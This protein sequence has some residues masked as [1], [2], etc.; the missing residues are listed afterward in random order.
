M[1]CEEIQ[2]RLDEYVDGSLAEAEFQAAELH[3]AGCEACRREERLL[4]A[5]LAHAEAL[6]EEKLPGRDLWTDIAARIREGN[7]VR[8]PVSWWRNPAALAA[9]AAV[10]LAVSGALVVRPG[11]MRGPAA[12]AS[13]S[14]EGVRQQAALTTSQAGLR[15]AEREYA[16]A[17]AE[18]MQVVEAQRASLSPETVRTIEENLRTID[19]ALAQ[20]RA[21]LDKDPTDA[22]L[23]H[24]L[25]AT[26]QKKVDALQRIVRLNRL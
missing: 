22:R 17:T 4:R 7:V 6:P 2:D 15:E 9:A 11:V 19:E 25:T 21:A 23:T 1:S 16:R 3:L 20:V 10:V 13:P 14:A 24:L 18:L 12:V 26:H 8:G 5:L